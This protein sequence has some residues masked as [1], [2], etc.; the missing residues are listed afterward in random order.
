MKQVVNGNEVSYKFH[1]SVALKP[2]ATCQVSFHNDNNPVRHPLAGNQLGFMEGRLRGSPGQIVVLLSPVGH[3][4]EVRSMFHRRD[5][6]R[7]V[8]QGYC[9]NGRESNP[10]Q[11]CAKHTF[12]SITKYPILNVS[13]LCRQGRELFI[14]MVV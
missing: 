2:G 7:G 12:S 13:E 5:G 10:D 1:R 6:S 8:A 9:W 4:D 14:P 11:Q 3:L